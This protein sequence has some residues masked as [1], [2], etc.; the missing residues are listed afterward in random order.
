MAAAA[1]PPLPVVEAQLECTPAEITF[2]CGQVGTAP[3][4]PANFEVV[5][6]NPTDKRAAFKVCVCVPIATV[7]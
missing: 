6:K 7:T 2:N 3:K 1:P 4:R 5:V